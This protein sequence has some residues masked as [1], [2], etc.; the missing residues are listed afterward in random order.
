MPLRD[1]L[2]VDQRC[3]LQ[4]MMLRE[5]IAASMVGHL[6]AQ[7]LIAIE[8]LCRRGLITYTMDGW[9]VNWTHIPRRGA[10]DL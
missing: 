8:A 9:R 4:W 5:P 2:T 10:D 3:I 6:P 7:S 1:D